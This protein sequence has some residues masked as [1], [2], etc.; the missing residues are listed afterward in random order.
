MTR[1]PNLV[2]I[3]FMGTG[4][5]AVGRRCAA[6][7]G[8][9]YHDMDMWI[10]RRVQKSIPEIFAEEGE[11]AFRQRERE[12]VQSLSMR[13]AIVL[14]T[15]GGAVMDPEN[16]RLLRECGVVVLLTASVETILSRVGGRGNRPL[17]QCDDPEAR[18]RDLLAQR[19]DVYRAA[20]HAVIDTGD[21]TRE[22]VAEEV[23]SIY[24]SR[25]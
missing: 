1:I 8:F 22:A 4:K 19:A 10:V 2:L 24:R 16:A 14:S 5:S 18:V 13:S 9:P 7:L 20:A 12:A 23:L 21:L 25:S 11:A 3:G 17:L 15:G 6:M